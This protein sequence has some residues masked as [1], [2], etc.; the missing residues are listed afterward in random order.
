MIFSM[1]EMGKCHVRVSSKTENLFC[2]SESNNT[3]K[4]KMSVKFLCEIGDLQQPV[5]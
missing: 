2:F 3:Q 5:F 4:Y 1:I